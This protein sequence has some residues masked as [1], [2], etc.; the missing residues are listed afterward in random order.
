MEAYYEIGSRKNEV[1]RSTG[2][3]KKKKVFR[4]MDSGICSCSLALPA[5]SGGELKI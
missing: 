5:S 1:W 3:V 4:M 2:Y